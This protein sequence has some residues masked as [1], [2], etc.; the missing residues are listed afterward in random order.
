M[1][2]RRAGSQIVKFDSRQLKVKNCFDFLT[3][4]WRV[5]YCWKALDEGYNFAWN[6]TS[7]EGLHTKLWASKV[8]RVPILGLSLWNLETKRHLGAGPMAKHREYY[9][10]KRWWLP[11]SFCHGESCEFMFARNSSVHQKCRTRH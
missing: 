2:K 1:A 8:A 4:N 9:K 10:G 11:Q 6:L 3:C 5:T 7:I